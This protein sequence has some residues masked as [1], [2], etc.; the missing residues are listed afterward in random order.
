MEG[1]R[2]VG[3]RGKADNSLKKRRG[4][5]GTTEFACSRVGCWGTEGGKSIRRD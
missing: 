5:K 4:T 2:D 1:R 3:W